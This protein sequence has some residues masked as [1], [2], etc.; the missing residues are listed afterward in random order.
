MVL[1]AGNTEPMLFS[2]FLLL[3]YV[4]QYCQKMSVINQQKLNNM[5]EEC[6][7][8]SWIPSVL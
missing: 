2:L 1:A 8:D 4:K 3:K 7:I 6:V 5:F